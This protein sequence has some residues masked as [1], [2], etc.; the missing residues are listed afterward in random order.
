MLPTNRTHKQYQN[1]VT[2]QIQL[3]YI[4]G[5]LQ[6]TATDWL[7]AEKLWGTDLSGTATFLEKQYGRRGPKPI[8]PDCMLRSYLLMLLTRQGYSITYWV[9]EMRRSPIFAILS[10]FEPGN[11]PGIGTFYDF[12]TRL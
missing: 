9:D 12:F 4:G 1:F 11:T 6:L 8:D 10:G 3:H 7:L 5:I 2:S